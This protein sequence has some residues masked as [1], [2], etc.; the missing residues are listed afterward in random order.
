MTPD[1]DAA[2]LQPGLISAAGVLHL[3]RQLAA[4]AALETG[5]AER[6]GS[7]LREM[8]LWECAVI[9]APTGER[10]ALELQGLF[11][12]AEGLSRGMRDQLTASALQAVRDVRTITHRARD[13]DGWI[14]AVPISAA[15]S[16]PR[17]LVAL[18]TSAEA[19]K[20][21]SVLALELTAATFTAAI[22]RERLRENDSDLARAA[23]VVELMERVLNAGSPPRSTDHVNPSRCAPHDPTSSRLALPAAGRLL[24]EELSRVL[25]GAAVLLG[26]RCTPQALVTVSARAGGQDLEWPAARLEALAGVLE[27]TLLRGRLCTWPVTSPE[28]EAGLLLHRQFVEGHP[29]SWL[30]STPLHCGEEA[31]TAVLVWGQGEGR[32][33]ATRLLSAAAGPVAAALGTLR[34]AERGPLLRAREWCRQTLARR[35]LWWWAALS[36]LAAAAMALPVP[37]RVR[38]D[39]VV[40]P[41]VRQFIAAPF[42]APLEA[43][44]VRPGDEVARD[45]V[46]ARLDGREIRWELAGLQADLQRVSR[47]RDGHLANRDAG[48]ARLSELERERLRLQS[49]LLEH[50]AESLEIRSP[51]DGIVIS[52]ELDDAIGAPLKIG[53]TLFELAPLQELVVELDVPERDITYVHAGQPV[54]YW[55]ESQPDVPLRGAIT[56]L[57]PRA[58]VRDGTSVFVAEVRLQNAAGWLRPGLSGTARIE[59]GSCRLGWCIFH[60]AWEELRMWLGV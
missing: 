2:P 16:P 48:A 59:V 43:A 47:E 39:C 26:T 52:G 40:E 1:V 44:L 53:E 30:V 51:I 38:C 8:Q 42:A 9:A 58:E 4:A 33:A 11:A 19:I 56:R 23:A 31:S 13:P 29:G 17:C 46:L 3:R 27:E 32:P 5:A 54:E 60:R 41:V 28:E 15:G 12:P 45:Q 22:E 49:Q 18:S 35:R 24:V 20:P 14:I 7:L 36:T 10:G 21:W 6:V 34:R 57:H 55:L 37:H 25:G 50:R